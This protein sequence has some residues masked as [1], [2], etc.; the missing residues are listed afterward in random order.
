MVIAAVSAIMET[1]LESGVWT[2]DDIW[3]SRASEQGVQWPDDLTRKWGQAAIFVHDSTPFE[4]D[5]LDG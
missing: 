5:P 4:G 1:T 2:M 3:V